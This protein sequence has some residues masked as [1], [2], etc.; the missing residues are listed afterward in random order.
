MTTSKEYFIV[1][2][3]MFRLDGGAMYGIIPKPLWE[4]NSP[5]DEHNRIDLALRLLLIKQDKRV[6]LIDT[7][8]GDYHGDKFDK[9]FDVRSVT[10]PLE[11]A[12]A[13][14]NLKP[15]DVTDLIISHL[16]FDHIG[17][18]VQ[19]V[20]S[21]IEPVLPNATLHLHKKHWEYALCPS[22][23]DRGSFQDKYFSSIIKEY[24]N[25]NKVNWIEGEEGV[26]IPEMNIKFITSHGHTPFM[27]HPYDE[28]MIY[29]ADIVPTSNHIHVPWVMAYDIA[30]A[31]STEDKKRILPFIIEN[32]LKM[33]FEHDP[34]F[35]G[36][37]L[38]Q[39]E[40]GKF[41]TSEKFE[42]KSNPAYS[43]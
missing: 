29:L 7:G 43:I 36:A 1:E 33:V 16:H 11:I 13:S 18:L 14:I 24:D 5:P 2:P 4:K 8:I 10:N 35:W 37:T 42:T 15:T 26:I 25:S 17:G 9:Q 30:P 6:V 21:K 34:K 12:L 32:K 41:K 20:N 3:A 19:N 27:C 23:R 22:D 39:D 40:R 38:T 31:V 28:E